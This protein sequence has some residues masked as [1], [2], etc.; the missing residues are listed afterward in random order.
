MGR[1]SYLR[2]N[3]VKR[4]G[5]HDGVDAGE[6][7]DFFVEAQ[8]WYRHRDRLHPRRRPTPVTTRN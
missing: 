8:T 7:V 6:T 1:Y 3:P 4:R 2:I 5:R